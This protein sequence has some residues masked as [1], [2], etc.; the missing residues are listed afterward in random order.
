V[1]GGWAY[2]CRDCARM[3]MAS[4][5]LGITRR[6][7]SASL[8]LLRRLTMLKPQTEDMSVPKG[9][10]PAGTGSDYRMSVMSEPDL[11]LVQTT[12]M[13]AELRKRYDV[14]TFAGFKGLTPSRGGVEMMWKGGENCRDELINILFEVMEKYP[15]NMGD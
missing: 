13:L 7:L 5:L 4:A 11:S 14:V 10:R 1:G 9:Y 15:M 3:N 2:F 8:V 6:C 12:D